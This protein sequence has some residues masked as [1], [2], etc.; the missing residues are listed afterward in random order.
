[1][2]WSLFNALETDDRKWLPRQKPPNQ[3]AQETIESPAVRGHLQREA[4][5]ARGLLTTGGRR[6]HIGGPDYAPPVSHC[7]K[8][9]DSQHAALLCRTNVFRPEMLARS[10]KLA[11]ETVVSPGFGLAGGEKL[12]DSPPPWR[13]K[14]KLRS[15]QAQKKEKRQRTGW[16]LNSDTADKG[17]T[18]RKL[19]CG[20]QI[21]LAA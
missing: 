1:M 8:A 4:C 19:S 14:P 21:I 17:G 20:A 10:S 2:G 9:Q 13:T 18:S 15:N 11:T 6:G 3:Q 7:Q 16:E 5:E 12:L